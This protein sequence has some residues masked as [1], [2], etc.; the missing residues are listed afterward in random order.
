[1]ALNPHVL[2]DNPVNSTALATAYEAM[3]KQTNPFASFLT[4]AGN[5]VK[6]IGTNLS[7]FNTA[8]LARELNNMQGEELTGLKNMGRGRYLDILADRGYGNGMVYNPDDARV[9]GAYSA[10][11][12]AERGQ[13]SKAYLDKVRKTKDINDL[14]KNA[15]DLDA[16]LGYYNRDYNDHVAADLILQ[17]GRD[18]WLGNQGLS[19]NFGAT[20]SDQLAN[21]DI[22]STW[23]SPDKIN[24]ENTKQRTNA[25]DALSK[26][27]T[28]AV[29]REE[30]KRGLPQGTLLNDREYMYDTFREY[31]QN[32]GNPLNIKESE[33]N[34]K[35]TTDANIKAQSDLGYVGEDKRNSLEIQSETDNLI[36]NFIGNKDKN[37]NDLYN[38]IQKIYSSRGKLFSKSSQTWKDIQSNIADQMIIDDVGINYKELTNIKDP[39]LLQPKLNEFINKSLQT[40]AN[41]LSKGL[42]IDTVDSS[43]NKAT[44]Q[45]FNQ[46]DKSKQEY[47]INKKNTAENALKKMEDVASAS[48][49][50]KAALMSEFRTGS[51]ENIASENYNK[52]NEA[53]KEIFEKLSADEQRQLEGVLKTATGQR[54]LSILYKNSIDKAVENKS[55]GKYWVNSKGYKKLQSGINLLLD[56]TYMGQIND[57]E[58]YKGITSL[59]SN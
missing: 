48:D 59:N 7:E 4:G 43:Y 5:Q 14:L 46:L 37:I 56:S 15:E 47:Y 16:S 1:M 29:M 23:F 49:P 11:D 55:D 35:D 38:G 17:G 53:Y 30:V 2:V 28:N 10:L 20:I 54:L 58:T 50:Q 25:I 18:T 31:M 9:T 52:I 40:K 36:S 8:N 41:M 45:L 6:T 13:Y 34:F 22:D 21:Q 33:V 19:N 26:D 51:A 3:G 39:N 57:Y 12:K 44:S 24:S 32:A 42:P 27:I